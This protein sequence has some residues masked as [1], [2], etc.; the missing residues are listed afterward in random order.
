[1]WKKKILPTDDDMSSSDSETEQNDVASDETLVSG[2][3]SNDDR[4]FIVGVSH[5][6]ETYLCSEVSNILYVR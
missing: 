3:D 2:N 6:L 1:M 5:D 4:T